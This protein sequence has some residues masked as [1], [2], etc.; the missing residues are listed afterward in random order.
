MLAKSGF[1]SPSQSDIEDED[2]FKIHTNALRIEND[3]Y[4]KDAEESSSYL[5][6]EDQKLND[7]AEL[8]QNNPEFQKYDQ[9]FK[10]NQG[11]EQ[12]PEEEEKEGEKIW[13]ILS[14]HNKPKKRALKYLDQLKEH[15]PQ[16]IYARTDN[17]C[18]CSH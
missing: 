12:I 9:L 2:D 8:S 7:M 3:D 5:L 11:Y 1:F 13:D 16:L 15:L 6:S 10:W 18:R 4:L 17:T 14:R